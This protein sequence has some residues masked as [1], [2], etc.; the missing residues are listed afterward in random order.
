VPN[1][2]ERGESRHHSA[3]IAK[4]RDEHDK[5]APTMRQACKPNL[6]TRP[7]ERQFNAAGGMLFRIMIS[8]G[9]FRL[10]VA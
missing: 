7:I 9:F 1:H 6:W 3:D 4:Q 2:Y 10:R 5:F 8:F